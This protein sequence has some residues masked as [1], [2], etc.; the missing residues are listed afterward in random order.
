MWKLDEEI[1]F[2]RAPE[3]AKEVKIKYR[4]AEESRFN[5]EERYMLVKFFGLLLSCLS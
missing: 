2:R 1:V 5:W 4:F 3:K